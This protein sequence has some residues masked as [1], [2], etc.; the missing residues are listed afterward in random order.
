MSGRVTLLPLI[1]IIKSLDLSKFLQ[2]INSRILG[3]D[4]M[5]YAD[6]EDAYIMKH[7]FDE[8]EKESQKDKIL[9]ISDSIDWKDIMHKFEEVDANGEEKADLP[10]DT[11]SLETKH[12]ETQQDHA[13]EKKKKKNKKKK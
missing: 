12:Q 10:Q 3:I 11:E 9:K 5:Y 1:C 6:K 8:K 13:E 7:F 4:V 2:T